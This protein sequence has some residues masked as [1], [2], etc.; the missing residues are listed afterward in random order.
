MGRGHV[1]DVV[2]VERQQGAE[3]GLLQLDLEAIET[4]STEPAHVE[5]VLPVDTIS[6]EGGGHHDDS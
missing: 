1:P 6:A 5:A 4:L 2:K 3:V